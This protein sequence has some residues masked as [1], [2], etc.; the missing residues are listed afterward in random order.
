MSQVTMSDA[1]VGLRVWGTVAVVSAGGA[2]VSLDTMVNIAFP[3]ITASFGIEVVDIQWVVTTYVLT[4]ASLLLAAG[5]LG[6]AFGHRR[7]LATGLVLSACG[8]GLCG[9]APEYGWFLLARLVQGAG[10]ALAMGSMPALVTLVVPERARH[11]A[12]GFFQMGAAI[13]LAIGPGLGGLLLQ[14]TSW[15]SVYLV[16]VPVA[17][18]VLALVGRVVPAPASGD[19]RATRRADES[20][21]LPG[22]VLVGAGLAAGLLALSRGGVSGWDAP[23]VV[24][25]FTLAVALL[26]VWV[27]VERR[28]SNPVIDLT[29][30]RSTPLT[31]AN[32]L[33][34]VAN[35]TMFAIWL[36]TPY[37]LVTV[38]GLSTIA[39]GLMLGVAPLATAV[40]A[41]LAGRILGRVSTDRLSSVGLALEAVGL[42]AVASTDADTPLLVVAGA[43]ALVGG[44]LGLFAVPNLLFVMGSIPRERQG[45][46]GAL[47]QMMRMIGVVAGVAGATLLF[48]AR[49]DAHVTDLAVAAD[50]PGAFVAAYRDTFAVV[51]ALC[52]A[53]IAVSL[54]R[55]A[56]DRTAAS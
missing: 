5:R 4:F 23:V 1:P 12:L 35:A 29:L 27:A 40:A 48:G 3:A 47:S 36:L 53:A 52:A 26:G 28:S 17:L 31:V 11:R 15:R 13:G 30:L 25:G 41:P 51:A 54:L 46:A 19:G 21:D 34:V 20:L 8:L 45:V 32:A 50:D 39:G 14:S 16:R 9:V 10:A 56:R 55:P 24:I 49:R 42:A 43:F 44:G 6:D 22:A 7:L 33:N 37:Y 18:I 2:L 38:R